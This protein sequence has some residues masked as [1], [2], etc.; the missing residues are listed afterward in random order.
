MG[1]AYYDKILAAEDTTC[2]VYIH[3]SKQVKSSETRKSRALIF[4]I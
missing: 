1:P 3:V 2:T 4:G